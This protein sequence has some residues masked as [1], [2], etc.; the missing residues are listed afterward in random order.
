MATAPSLTRTTR[1]LGIVE[2]HECEPVDDRPGFFHVTDTA[3]GSGKGYTT[4]A[5]SCTCPDHTF[6][7]H[8]CKH[9]QAVMRESQLLTA[10]SVS[11][12]DWASSQRPCCPRCGAELVS[13]LYWIGGRGY[14]AFA[15]CG[16]DSSHYGQPA[17]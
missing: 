17:A 15:V 16:D 6:R 2:C 11:W 7:G 13:R 5:T 3:T 4:S 1:A 9:M 8:Q 12:D 10:Y 14:L